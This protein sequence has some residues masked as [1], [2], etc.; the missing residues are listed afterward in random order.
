MI[1]ISLF[2][3]H[4]VADGSRA[5]VDIFPFSALPAAI[6]VWSLG[7]VLGPVMVSPLYS[8]ASVRER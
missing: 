3:I 5:S 1:V 4:S 2:S 8:S 6:G 7:A